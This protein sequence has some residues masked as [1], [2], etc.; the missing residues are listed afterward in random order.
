MA[1]FPSVL[2]TNRD[3]LSATPVDQGTAEMLARQQS[4]SIAVTT[5]VPLQPQTLVYAS[6][7]HPWRF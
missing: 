3:S 4:S 1:R 2:S 5:G 7:H 6:N